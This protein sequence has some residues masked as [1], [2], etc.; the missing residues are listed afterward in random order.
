MSEMNYDAAT[1]GNRHFDNG[2]TK[3]NNKLR[4]AKF[5]FL[6]IQIMI[7]EVQF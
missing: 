5:S 6:S 2:I 1:L 4:Y 7:S 3:L